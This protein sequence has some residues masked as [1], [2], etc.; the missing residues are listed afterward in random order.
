[1]QSTN[2][3]QVYPWDRIMMFNQAIAY[4][5]ISYTITLRRS[6]YHVGSEI[7][8]CVVRLTGTAQIISILKFLLQSMYT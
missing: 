5:N 8:L 4:K 2:T 7:I 1:M 6:Q 3:C